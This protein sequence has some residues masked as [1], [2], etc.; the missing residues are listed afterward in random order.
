MST[1][2]QDTTTSWAEDKERTF[3]LPSPKVTKHLTISISGKLI[4]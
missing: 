1:D 4:M 2:T 3:I